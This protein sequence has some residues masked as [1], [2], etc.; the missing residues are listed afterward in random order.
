M[1]KT[2]GMLAALCAITTSSF[3]YEYEL[4]CASQEGLD[5]SL[6]RRAD[7]YNITNCGFDLTDQEELGEVLNSYLPDGNY[8]GYD[9][10]NKR[11]TD[12]TPASTLLNDLR[13]AHYTGTKWSDG[14]VVDLAS[15]I[16]DNNA[17]V[18]YG[19]AQCAFSSETPV[20]VISGDDNKMLE[21]IIV[22]W[23]E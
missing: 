16:L 13:K 20:K 22:H 18:Y 23:S 11:P 10:Y 2:L 21:F 19:D 14:E 4:Q 7:L 8:C 3:A 17:R 15:W 6:E 9:F 1:K 5:T 12:T